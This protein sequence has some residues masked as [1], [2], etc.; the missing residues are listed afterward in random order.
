MDSL[1]LERLAGGDDLLFDEAYDL[2]GTLMS[3]ELS[4][5]KIAAMLIAL[6]MKGETVD[7]IAGFA[8]AMRDKS[9]RITPNRTDLVDTCGTGGDGQNT[10]NI[11]TATALVTASMGI[12]VA[13]HGNRAVSSACGSADVLE[14]MGVNLD[15]SPAMVT[16]LID[17]VGV[18]FMFAP[19]MHPA[20]KHAV[21]V[22]KQLGVRTVFN[23]LGPLTNP[24]RVKRQL[25]GVFREDLTEPMC[26]V[27]ARLGSVKAFVVHGHDGGDE[28]SIT[29]DTIVSQLENGKVK[30]FRFSPED[31]GLSPADAKDI[32]GGTAEENAGHITSILSG[33]KGPRRDAILINSGFTAVL[34]GIADEISDG[35]QMAATSIDSGR[36]MELLKRFIATSQQSEGKA[37]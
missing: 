19:K 24:A 31:A 37:S 32:R 1:L 25:L 9:V 27:L 18:G 15:L 20:M 6:R 13:K 12:G 34:A 30:T 11:S 7:E 36:A 16:K 28:V 5:A 2:M 4:E 26:L 35:V 22:R 10:F 8:A 23:I 21:P 14:T 33:T 17:E 29:G 3:G